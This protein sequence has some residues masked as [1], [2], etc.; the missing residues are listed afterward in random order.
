MSDS[1][2][3][4]TLLTTVA[5]ILA[6]ALLLIGLRQTRPVPT[7]MQGTEKHPDGMAEMLSNPDQVRI[8]RSLLDQRAERDKS[9]WADEVKAQKYEEPFVNLWD[10]LRNSTDP[11]ATLAAFKFSRLT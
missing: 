7:D 11:W 5:A 8:A 3:K 1:D 4:G 6:V 10:E 2:S 9:I